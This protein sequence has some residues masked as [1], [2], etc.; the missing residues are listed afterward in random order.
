MTNGNKLYSIEEIPVKLSDIFP[1]HS[2]SFSFLKQTLKTIHKHL[3]YFG[4]PSK[5]YGRKLTNYVKKYSNIKRNSVRGIVK[6][7]Q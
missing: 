4:S 5:S 7:I 1:M 6:D 2:S 3:K